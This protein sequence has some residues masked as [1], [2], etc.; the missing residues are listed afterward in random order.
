MEL[1]DALHDHRADTRTSIVL[2]G[3]EKR[4]EHVA[5]DVVVHADTIVGDGKIHMPFI[6][7]GREFLVLSQSNSTGLA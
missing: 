3:G 1:Y 5:F 4:L 2:C 7:A 6:G